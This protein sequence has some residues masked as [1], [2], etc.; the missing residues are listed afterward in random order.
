[1][2]TVLLVSLSA[3]PSQERA[4]VLDE[5]GDHHPL[6]RV[7]AAAGGLG[8]AANRP[9]DYGP[10]V[11]VGVPLWLGERGLTQFVVDSLFTAAYGLASGRVFLLLSPAVGVNYDF[12]HGVGLELRLG[13]GVGLTTS[14]QQAAVTLGNHL[15]ASFVLR[16]FADDHARLKLTVLG[17]QCV[18]L[19]RGVFMQ[20]LVGGV[21]FELRL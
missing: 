2:L 6:V 16:P 14:T 1:M 12:A 17:E 18:P 11:G 10:L 19:K 13:I 3:L 15:E 7:V 9:A 21:G 4:F 8:L 5:E 20:S